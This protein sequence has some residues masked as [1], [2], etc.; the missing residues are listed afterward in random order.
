MSVNYSESFKKFHLGCGINFL[1]NYLNIGFWTNLEQNKLYENPNGVMNTVLL[2]FDLT[3]GIP[4]SDNSL[5]VVYHSHMLEHLTNIEGIQFLKE[6]NRVLKPGATMR[7]LVPDL[8]VFSKKYIEKDKFFFDA[9]RKEVL[10]DD[11]VLYP[12]LGTVFM[13]MVHNHGHKMAY[14][15]ETI[16][17]I[18]NENGFSDIRKT[19]FQESTLNDI[20]DIEPYSPLRAIESLCVE[21]IKNNS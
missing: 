5:D 11:K 18:L 8:G 15:F 7:L 3:Q 13:G 2:N 4:A 20:Q 21:C 14:D 1:K 6:C 10:S 16:E 12:T 17:N 19:M 9:Y